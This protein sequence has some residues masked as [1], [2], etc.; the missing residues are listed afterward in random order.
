M[1]ID[2]SKASVTYDNAR[3]SDDIIIGIMSKKN[4]FVKNKN[5]LDFGCGTGNYLHNIS[6]NYDCT[7]YGVE[8][9]V[10][11]RQKAI[12]KNPNLVILEG[13]HENIPFDNNFFDLVYM[14][15]VVH[16]VPDLNIMFKNFYHKINENGYIC[17]CTQ[18]WEQI[19]NRW[20]NQYFPSLANNEKKRYPDID[21]IVNIAK[22]NG[23]IFESLDIKNNSEENVITD[24]FISLVREKNY[25]MFRILE[26]DEYDVGLKKLEEDNG[27]IVISK[28]AGESLIW[29]KKDH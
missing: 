17:I 16:H 20:Y 24:L 28:N 11:M 21:T 5:I 27:K 1:M 12:D 29:F 18:S 25:S 2:Y 3:N 10:E 13:N 26:K 6:N 8:P 9:S 15:D 22:D 14:T 23:I 7:C 4:I 19:E